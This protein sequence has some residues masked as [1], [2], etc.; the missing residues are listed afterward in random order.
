[1]STLFKESAEA[2]RA[3]QRSTRAKRAAAGLRAELPASLAQVRAIQQEAL[4]T[5]AQAPFRVKRSQ[6]PPGAACKRHRRVASMPV[7]VGLA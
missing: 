3:V 7:P 1:M 6:A 2:A 5:L 4:A